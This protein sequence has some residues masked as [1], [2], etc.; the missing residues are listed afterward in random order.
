MKDTSGKKIE[1]LYTG[2]KSFTYTM[3]HKRNPATGGSRVSINRFFL[4]Y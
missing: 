1:S 4:F 2:M 3:M